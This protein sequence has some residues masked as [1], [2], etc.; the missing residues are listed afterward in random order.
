MKDIAEKMLSDSKA[1]EGISSTAYFDDY[2][3][4]DELTS[5]ESAGLIE[6]IKAVGKEQF[7]DERVHLHRGNANPRH[8]IVTVSFEQY[9]GVEV[10]P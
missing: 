4:P 6:A 5:E 10:N 9:L 3:D 8:E 1:D 2:I 7:P